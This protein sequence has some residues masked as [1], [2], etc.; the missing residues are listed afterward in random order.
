MASLLYVRSVYSLLSSMCTIPRMVKKAKEKGYSSIGLVDKNVLSGAMS[1]YN[2]CLKENIKPVIGLEVDVNVDRIVSVI[3]YAKDDLGFQNL[4]RL[5]SVV[6]TGVDKIIDLKTFN[7]YRD[8]NFVVIKSEDVPYFD[9]EDINNSIKKEKEIFGDHLVAFLD[10]DMAGNVR[11]DEKLRPLLNENKIKIIKMST[12]LYI[13]EDDYIAYEVLKC[14]R[15]KRTLE[16]NA[17]YERDRQIKDVFDF[18]DEFRNCDIL[19]NNCNVKMAF[20]TSLPEFKTP[21]DVSSKDYLSALCKEGL[22]RRLK[23]RLTNEYIS[24]LQYE[25]DVIIKMHF[26][27]YFLIVYDFILCAKKKGIMVGPGRGSAA[28]SLVSYYGD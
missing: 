19:A 9:S 27:D 25:L 24:R 8:H 26:E 23:N 22:K 11:R 3:L 1:F 10:A 7:K 18:D 15:D 13:E 28:G 2:E 5:S 21:N 20:R 16:E 6:N 12:T 14:I 17:Y 4:M